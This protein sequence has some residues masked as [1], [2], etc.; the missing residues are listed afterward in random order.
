[1]AEQLPIL[2]AEQ[3]FVRFGRD[4]IG[5]GAV[6]ELVKNQLIDAFRKEIFGLL[7]M[8]IKP[9]MS[10]EEKEKV[11][12]NVYRDEQK[13]WRK[14]AGMFARYK[15]TANLIDK[16]NIVEAVTGKVKTVG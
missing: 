12:Q 14:L 1:M 7:A 13:K 9:N 11:R 4:G 15:E 10:E 8:R 2:S 16:I 5:K 3:Y 6:R